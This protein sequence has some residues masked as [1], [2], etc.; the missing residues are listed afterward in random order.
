LKPPGLDNR[1]FVGQKYH[2]A[3]RWREWIALWQ[4]ILGRFDMKKSVQL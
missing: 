1:S 4:Q 3:E 2:R